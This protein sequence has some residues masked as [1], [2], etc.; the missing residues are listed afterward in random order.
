MDVAQ[1]QTM[2]K[3]SITSGDDALPAP[4]DRSYEALLGGNRAVV[5]IKRTYENLLAITY[6]IDF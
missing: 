2:A 4:A 1:Q 3:V 6:E 5:Y